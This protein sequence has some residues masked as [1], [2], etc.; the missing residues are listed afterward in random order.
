LL[1]LSAALA[2]EPHRAFDARVNG[3]AYAPPPAYAPTLELLKLLLSSHPIDSSTG[4]EDLLQA[5]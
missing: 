1:E 2:R 5:A 4:D 3:L